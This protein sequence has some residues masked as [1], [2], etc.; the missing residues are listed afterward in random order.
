MDTLNIK[1]L[2]EITKFEGSRS[3]IYSIISKN[4]P[5]AIIDNRQAFAIID[6]EKYLIILKKVGRNY[7]VRLIWRLS[8]NKQF[9]F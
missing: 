8:D 9:N 5:M 3:E 6:D 7:K 4:N 1:G 2:E